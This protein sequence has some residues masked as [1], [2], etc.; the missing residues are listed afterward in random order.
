MNL[1]EA[2]VEVVWTSYSAG[3]LTI[4][5]REPQARRQT[6]IDAAHPGAGVYQSVVWSVGQA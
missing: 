2:N 3:R 1:S 6:R 5:D 4:D